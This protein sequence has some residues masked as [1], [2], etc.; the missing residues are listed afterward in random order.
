MTTMKKSENILPTS[1]LGF[2]KAF[3]TLG[4]EHILQGFLQD[5]LDSDKFDQKIT[6]VTL[7]NP[8]NIVDV[9][10]LSADERKSLLLNTIIDIHC[11]LGDKRE[12]VIEM[13][14]EKDQ[15]M[16]ERIFYNSALKYIENYD[17][18]LDTDNRSERKGGQSKYAS[19]EPV[20]SLNVF[21]Y[22]HFKKSQRSLH[23]FRLYDSK[24]NKYTLKNRYTEIYF[25]LK[26]KDTA[27]STNLKAWQHFMLTGEVMLNAPS[28][29]KEAAEMLNISNLTRDERKAH[30]MYERNRRKMLSREAYVREKGFEEGV[31]ETKLETAKKLLEMGLSIED[32]AK[33]LG[34]DS[35]FV[36]QLV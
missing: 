19:L 31:Q 30:D 17:R 27:L 4:K 34:L 36:Q 22:N 3:S 33:A 8:Y 23:F 29:V 13:Q 18:I 25:E 28:Y 11:T 16:E 21:R 14:V 26:K 32:S 15:E 20:I 6:R 12:I 9:N 35:N 5:V 1:D 2:R 24:D 10:K 7:G